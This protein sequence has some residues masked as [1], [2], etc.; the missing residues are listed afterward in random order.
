MQFIWIYFDCHTRELIVLVRCRHIV[1]RLCRNHAS[2][3]SIIFDG[4]RLFMLPVT[5]NSIKVYS[6]QYD[7]VHPTSGCLSTSFREL[8][9]QGGKS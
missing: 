5:T 3:T 1:L 2:D 6:S 4:P 7:A 9:P 8:K